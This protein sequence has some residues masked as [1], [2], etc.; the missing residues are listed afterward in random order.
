MELPLLD[1][2]G[3]PR[4]ICILLKQDSMTFLNKLLNLII[5]II[6]NTI[7]AILLVMLIV[8]ITKLVL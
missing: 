4:N 5:F 3:M 8:V 6:E 7:G 1:R 2:E